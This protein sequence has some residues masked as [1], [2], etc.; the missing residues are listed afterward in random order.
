MKGLNCYTR[1][2]DEPGIEKLVTFAQGKSSFLMPVIPSDVQARPFLLRTVVGSLVCPS[3]MALRSRPTTV[4]FYAFFVSVSG[5]CVLQGVHSRV[6]RHA[7]HYQSSGR[8]CAGRVAS[9]RSSPVGH[10]F[11]LC[12]LLHHKRAANIS[13]VLSQFGCL[14]SPHFLSV[15]YIFY[16]FVRGLISVCRPR[17]QD[18]IA[19][20][21]SRAGSYKVI[22]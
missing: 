19:P 2:R 10:C 15:S 14:G 7:G 21:L 3:D 20:I 6:L 8:Q 9:L 16:C 17:L 1:F 13:T 4:L 11:F 22:P 18:T 5:R 12:F